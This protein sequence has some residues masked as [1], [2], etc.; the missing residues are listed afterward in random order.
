MDEQILGYAKVGK[1]SWE[2][3]H[4]CKRGYVY[5]AAVVVCQKCGKFIRGMGGPMHARCVECY[6]QIE[7]YL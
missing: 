1:D 4:Q 6:N 2:P 5:S 3:I 7:R